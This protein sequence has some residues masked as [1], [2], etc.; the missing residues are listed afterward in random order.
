MGWSES[1]VFWGIVTICLGC[2]HLR[3]SSHHACVRPRGPGTWSSWPTLQALA[4]RRLWEVSAKS[5]TG[6]NSSS[7]CS[8]TTYFHC[9]I[10][11][12]PLLDLE[13][14]KHCLVLHQ[15]LG[16]A[17]NH[18]WSLGTCWVKIFLLDGT[19]AATGTEEH[20]NLWC[21]TGFYPKQ[22]ARKCPF[23][24]RVFILGVLVREAC[25]FSQGSISAFPACTPLLDTFRHTA[26]CSLP[27]HPSL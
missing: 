8:H 20:R 15:I 7:S 13:G 22:D 14:M 26:H 19:L 4:Q 1:L 6:L 21:D 18:T 10:G 16:R 5:R 17:Q 27:L 3:D 25:C 23:L 12:R 9:F 11:V 24:G 2:P